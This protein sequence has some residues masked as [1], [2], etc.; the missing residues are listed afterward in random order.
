M[1]KIFIL[2]L[3]FL[4]LTGCKKEI[5]EDPVVTYDYDFLDYIN[6]NF[7]G[8]DGYAELDITISDFTAKDFK[9]EED[10][11]KVKKLITTLFPSIKASKSENL[12]NGD[13]IQV[14]ITSGFDTSQ[15]GDL[16]INLNVHEIEVN[17]LPDP[18]TISLFDE[19]NIVFYGLSGTSKVYYYYPSSSLLT[20]EMKDNLIYDIQI[21]DQTVQK[22]KTVLTLKAKLNQDLLESDEKYGTENRYFGAQGYI[23]ELSDEKILKT[24]VYESAFANA[25][26][27]VI[28]DALEP[29]I[30]EVGVDGYDFQQI[31]SIQKT[32]TPFKYYVVAKYAKE[33]KEIYIKYSVSMAYV[34][35]SLAVYSLSRESTTDIAF[36]TKAYEDC[37]IVHQYE[38]F[39]IVEEAEETETT[40]NE[41]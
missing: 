21:D 35:N 6:L 27:K 17:G 24:V 36:T 28:R 25:D 38:V 7:V 37:E 18:K 29:Q 41:N 14:G 9:S 23:T 34:D 32:K 19:N 31:M 39:E 15:T 20:N 30:K 4:C 11:I 3:C 8:P 16:N 2:L 1:K 33:T 10:Y 13:V 5:E 22:D 26:K 40:E 12:T